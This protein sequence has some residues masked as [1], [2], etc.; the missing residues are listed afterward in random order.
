MEKFSFLI[1]SNYIMRKKENFYTYTH[2]FVRSRQLQKN[3]GFKL[4]S[5]VKHFRNFECSCHTRSSDN[6]N[7]FNL[8]RYAKGTIQFKKVFVTL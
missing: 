7:K 6:D 1:Y 5:C 8:S 4:E 2:N 3:N